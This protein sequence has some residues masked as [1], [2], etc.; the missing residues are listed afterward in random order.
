MSVTGNIR[1]QRTQSS[2][3]GY[4]TLGSSIA[5]GIGA[6]TFK[7]IYVNAFQRYNG[8]SNLAI[9]S[10][11]GIQKGDYGAGKSNSLTT[12]K[13]ASYPTLSNNKN[14]G[15]ITTPQYA[16]SLSQVYLGATVSPTTSTIQVDL[17]YM[18]TN[19]GIFQEPYPNNIYFLLD[20][21]IIPS[22]LYLTINSNQTLNIP[23]NSTLTVNNN[24]TNNGTINVESCP[25]NVG[26][27]IAKNGY[28]GNGKVTYQYLPTCP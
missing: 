22:N 2:T 17:N 5:S 12:V 18:A 16:S 8:D 13:S 26:A 25:D 11:L 23:P 7:R 6:G 20:S 21:F 3:N 19:Y 15:R 27:I 9:S 10:T 14:A 4:K 24:L 1:G 28:S